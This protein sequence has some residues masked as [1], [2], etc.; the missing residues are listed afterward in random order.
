RMTGAGLNRALPAFSV[1]DDTDAVFEPDAGMLAAARIVRAQVEL[2]RH[3]GGDTTRVLENRPVRRVDL[4]AQRPALVTD[5]GTI[6][7]DRLIVT[8]GPWTAR[9]FPDWPAPLRPTR[10]PVLY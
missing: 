10:Q 8:A 3:L 2:A 4:G 7:A 5:A 6:V 9:L 1:P